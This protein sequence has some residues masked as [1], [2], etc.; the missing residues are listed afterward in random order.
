MRILI[1]LISLIYVIILVF[2]LIKIISKL[3]LIYLIKNGKR[4]KLSGNKSLN[5]GDPYDF[6]RFV[7]IKEGLI[8]GENNILKNPSDR[9]LKCSKIILDNSAEINQEFIKDEKIHM[10]K[11]L[12]KTMLHIVVAILISIFILCFIIFMHH[13]IQ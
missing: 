12:S 2:N 6:L 5:M 13:K 9:I 8:V 3:K 7:I 10:C 1:Y 11:D 4:L